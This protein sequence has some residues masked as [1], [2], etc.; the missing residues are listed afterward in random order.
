MNDAM[1]PVAH[2]RERLRIGEIRLPDCDI[3]VAQKCN[4]QCGVMFQKIQAMGAR[5]KMPCSVGPQIPRR[6]G[7]ED[8]HAAFSARAMNL[9][10]YI[11]PPKSNSP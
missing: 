2:S 5:Q 9:R 1:D 11:I 10:K 4:G 7:D 3:G 8:I 6:P